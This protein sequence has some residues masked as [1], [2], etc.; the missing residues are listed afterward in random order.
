MEASKRHSFILLLFTLLFF[1]K[2]NARNYFEIVLSINY[3]CSKL[4]IQKTLHKEWMTLHIKDQIR[5][6]QRAWV[7]GDEEKY[8]Q[9]REMVAALICSV[10]SM[11]GKAAI[12]VIQI[13]AMV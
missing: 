6:M 1:K 12:S 8:Q 2:F 13:Q 3:K 10:N 4:R 7:K 9:K 5:A 11:K